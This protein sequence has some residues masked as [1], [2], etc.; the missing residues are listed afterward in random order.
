MAESFSRKK[1]RQAPQKEGGKIMCDLPPAQCNPAAGASTRLTSRINGI[2]N[3]TQVL[4][5]HCCC[6]LPLV[7]LVW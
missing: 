1:L 6:L 3:N 2:K 7:G 4:L 5:L